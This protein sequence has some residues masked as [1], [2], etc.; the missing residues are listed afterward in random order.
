M[1]S[2]IIKLIGILTALTLI[3]CFSGCAPENN[4]NQ[5][6]G[7]PEF[8]TDNGYIQW[9]SGENAQWQNLIALSELKGAAGAQGPAGA[10]G[11]A[12]AEGPQGDTGDRGLRGSAGATGPAGATGATGPQGAAGATGATG[13]QGETGATG[14]TGPQGE[15]GATGP[16]GPA[17]A[18]GQP[19]AL[20]SA[21]NNMQ[22]SIPADGTSVTVL[23]LDNVNIADSNDKVKI[24]FSMNFSCRCGT[25][26]YFMLRA[27]L[28]DG[29][30]IL[31][32]ADYPV[33]EQNQ[34]ITFT[35]SRICIV[36]PGAAGARNYR[37][38]VYIDSPQDVTNVSCSQLQMSALVFD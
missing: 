23:N 10:T 19:A 5:N 30:V 33:Y 12:G 37:I 35:L 20:Y 3:A 34:D 9:R 36:Q 27:V 1:K 32:R 8:R 17:G 15:T 38:N 25:D 28:Y 24:D 7:A 2:R 16:Q 6:Q 21:S 29:D 14:P 11:A 13:P 4:A 26:D 31:G 22:V 18:T